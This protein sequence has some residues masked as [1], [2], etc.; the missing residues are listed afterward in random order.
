[1]KLTYVEIG[2]IV[3]THGVRGELKLRPLDVEAELLRRCKTFYIDGAPVSP[4]ARRIHKGCLLFQLPGVD[5]VDAALPY[6]G[7]TV[8]V[9]RSELPLPEGAYLPAEL[10]GMAVEDAES[11]AALGK[12]A[13]V[14][15][16]PAHDVYVVRGEKEFMVPAVE[17]FVASVDLEANVMKIH[18]WEG[19]I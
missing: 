11:G 13:G 1:M 6:K 17:A 9:R 12:I 14:I 8:S 7:K 15:P 19:L 16:Y 10:M 2:Q 4:T 18:V 3:N 5:S